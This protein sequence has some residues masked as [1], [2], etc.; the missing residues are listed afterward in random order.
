[1][2]DLTSI[3]IN[4]EEIER[5]E[6]LADEIEITDKVIINIKWCKGCGICVDFCP[7]KSLGMGRDAKAHVVDLESCNNCGLCYLRCP[8][9]AIKVPGYKG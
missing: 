5:R 9:F 2:K 1:M 6:E 8:D 4:D 7:K 3:W